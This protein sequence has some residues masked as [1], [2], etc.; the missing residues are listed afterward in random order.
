MDTVVAALIASVVSLLVALWSKGSQEATLRHQE[1]RLRAEL[2]MHETQLRAEAKLQ[3]DRLRAE[4]RT[5]FMAEEAIRQL[6][7]HPDWAQRS[8]EA[9]KRRLGGF[10]DDELRRHLVRAGAVAFWRDS[11]KK[12]WWGLRERNA[13]ELGG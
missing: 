8:F 1:E 4:L 2:S 7:Q 9:I 3:E 6:L 12:E 13:N 5:E 10:Q 11:G